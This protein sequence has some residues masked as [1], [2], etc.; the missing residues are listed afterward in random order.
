M[1][2]SDFCIKFQAVC[3]PIPVFAKKIARFLIVYHKV[4][5]NPLARAYF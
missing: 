5:Y 2:H 4:N 3:D 1:L